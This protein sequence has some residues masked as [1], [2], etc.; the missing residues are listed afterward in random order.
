MEKIRRILYS[1]LAFIFSGCFSAR[2]PANSF[3]IVN[4]NV[5]TFFDGNCDGTEYSNFTKS[6]IWGKESY[7]KRLEK[8]CAAINSINADIFVFE[9]I[10]N[11]G[12]LYDITNFMSSK[13]WN[14]KD[15]WQYGA[16]SKNPGDA[17]GCAV[18]SKF[19]ISEVTIHNI[20]IRTENSEQPAMRPLMKL[21]I[22]F[23]GKDFCVFVSHWKSKSGGAEESEVW[24]NWQ[25]SI[26]AKKI[27]E[28]K[29]FPVLACG[30]FNRDISEF[31][32]AEYKS[33]KN[34]QNI[35]LRSFYTPENENAPVYSPWLDTSGEQEEP[36]SYYFKDTWERID[37]FFANDKITI[38]NFEVLTEG[39]W[40]GENFI[41][42]A[43]KI[44]T[45][46]GYSDHLPI[47]CIATAN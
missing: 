43:Y 32:S 20:D 39:N 42:K 46:E 11:S 19:P 31:K 5:Q 3:S 28:H 25:E 30:D 35:E 38:K 2:I 15:S 23:E 14:T 6:Q 9:E 37:H 22:I 47:K 41:P 21:N 27:N 29:N 34:G 44:Y 16:F 4:W 12:I 8:L 36:G 18:I 7:K 1:L 10:E 40:C 13:S 33:G 24:R 26:L 17:I 45:G